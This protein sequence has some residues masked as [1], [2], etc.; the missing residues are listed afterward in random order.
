MEQACG[1]IDAVAIPAEQ[2]AH[3]ERVTQIVK[4]RRCDTGRDRETE[5]RDEVMERLSDRAR[6]NRPSPSER[7]H[8]CVWKQLAASYLEIAVKQSADA[9]PE[10]DKPAL[11][12]LG[13]ADD[14]QPTVEVN[15][16]TSETRHLTHA[17][18]QALQEGEDRP[19]CGP[20][21]WRPR[22]HG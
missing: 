18:P 15:V 12:E 6:V 20:S 8:G 21:Q 10:G 11:S 19:V 1:G 5:P 22:S 4:S 3:S 17:K 14:E 2:G 13:G 7:E 16:R 9:R